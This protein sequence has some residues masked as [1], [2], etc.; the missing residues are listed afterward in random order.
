MNSLAI[1]V[2]SGLCNRLRVVLS[3][4]AYC[5]KTNRRLLVHWPRTD[6]HATEKEPDRGFEAKLSDLFDGPFDEITETEFRLFGRKIS[7]KEIRLDTPGDLQL[8]TINM[9]PGVEPPEGFPRKHESHQFLATRW[10]EKPL[11]EYWSVM[12]PT[13]EL[14]NWISEGKSLVDQGLC[15]AA[16]V[17]LC[18]FTGPEGNLITNANFETPLRSPPQKFIARLDQLPQFNKIFLAC[19]CQHV[20]DLFRE[21]F[22]EQVVQLPQ[23]YVY[24]RETIFKRM[25]ELYVA[26]SCYK[27]LG[28][29]I[30]SYSE[31][32]GWL[33]GGAYSACYQWPKVSEGDRYEDVGLWE[34]Q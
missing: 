2:R 27:I 13:A 3:A 12:K 19:D 8:R 25:A 29:Y 32:S 26:A 1:H 30:S 5:E 24:D 28:S 23:T 6:P 14:Q 10:Y 7:Q 31:L 15:V 17:R 16:I 4:L 9:F 34:E 33:A 20:E 18:L 21:A 11:A 22:P